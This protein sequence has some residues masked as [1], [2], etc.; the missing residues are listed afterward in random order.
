MKKHVVLLLILSLMISLLAM[1]C[2][3]TPAD[4]NGGQTATKL[5]KYVF[6]FIGDGM[7]YP[8]IQVTNYYLTIQNNGN[9]YPAILKSEN[10]L[11]FMDFPV[12]GSAQTY[13]SSSFAPDSSSTATA[14]ATGN[15]TYSGYLNIGTNGFTKFETIAEKLKAQQGYKIGV[16]TSVN[17]N[18]ATPGAFYAH[19]SS[20]TKYHQI[21][22][23]LVAS[24][25]D[26]FAGGAFREPETSMGKEN[27][28]ALAT[29]AG[30][31]VVRTQ[32][33]AAALKPGD[34]KAIVIAE[35]LVPVDMDFVDAMDYEIDRK[36]GEWALADYVAK[37][38]EML[39][40]DTGFFMM[41]E[42]GKIDWACH[43]N[44]AATA[45]HEVI[46]LNNAVKEAL[47]FYEEHPDD[48]L[49][50][51]TGDHETGGF[52]LG[53][54]GTDYDTFLNNLASQKISYSTF[55]SE[56]VAKYRQQGTDLETVLADIEELF[57][58][59]VPANLALAKAGTLELNKYE[60]DL[61]VTAYNQTI[62]FGAD[63]NANEEEEL[64]YD[65]YEP[66]TVTITH[67]LA[68]KCGLNFGSYVHTGLPTAVFAIGAGS[69]L[70]D[71]YYDNTD[72]FFKMA[73]LTKVQ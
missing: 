5:P 30:Y 27:L 39:N 24:G 51:V 33:E 59:K 55:N 17:I 68:N 58:L 1:G 60:Y 57:G 63:K 46:A 62:Q 49:I 53:Y 10:N 23:E 52:T 28:Y 64:K 56:Y 9:K 12:S 48:T 19:Q 66:L 25:F 50:I 65:K 44:D 11:C 69:E 36:E 42:G 54:A 22:K 4:T 29:E 73:E 32:A 8:Q 18:H 26:Y 15:K 7:S 45:V 70:F 67:I 61:L 41:V 37:G 71:G 47:K 6:L 2:T 34:G 40:N 43:A 3:Q 20:R 72:I 35:H 16:V 13:D 21:G 14:M 31:K 38:I